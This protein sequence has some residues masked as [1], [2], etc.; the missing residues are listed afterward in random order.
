MGCDI[1]CEV[2]V[3]RKGSWQ[4]APMMPFS[5]RSYSAFAF[6]ADVRNSER[7]I[8]PLCPRKGIPDD[9]DSIWYTKW[10]GDAHSETWFSAKELSEVDPFTDEMKKILPEEYRWGIRSMAYLQEDID[11]GKYEDARV[12]IWF[13]N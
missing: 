3:K 5:G 12:V 8:T 2:Q 13:D 4:T 10:E 11:E 1:H 7:G 9:Y 6:L